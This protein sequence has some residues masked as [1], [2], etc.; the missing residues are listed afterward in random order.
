VVPAYPVVQALQVDVL[1]SELVHDS[2]AAVQLVI[3]GHMLQL[4]L[5]P[6]E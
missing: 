2:P 1:G 3:G 4:L 6:I 5:P